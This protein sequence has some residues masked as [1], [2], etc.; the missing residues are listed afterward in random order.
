MAAVASSSCSAHGIASGTI[1]NN[2]TD[3]LVLAGGTAIVNDSKLGGDE[4]VLSGGRLVADCRQLRLRVGCSF[5]RHR[6][7]YDRWQLAVSK[8]S[9]Q[10]AP[11]SRDRRV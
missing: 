6:D 10:A 7:R 8:T 11:R 2:D 3:Q 5:W 1:L 4:F 9:S